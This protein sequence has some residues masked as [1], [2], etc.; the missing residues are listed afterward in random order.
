MF[1]VTPV[2][3]EWKVQKNI[4]EVNAALIR[5]LKSLKGKVAESNGNYIRCEFGSLLISRLAGE[6]LVSKGTLPKR[7]EIH[8]ERLGGSET[9]L[10]LRVRDTHKYGL[11]TLYISKYEEALEELVDSIYKAVQ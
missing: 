3:K 6:L 2:E 7:A 1:N 8:L 11:K 10:K 5:V 4:D 9:R